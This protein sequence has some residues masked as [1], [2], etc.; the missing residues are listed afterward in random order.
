MS[1]LR[2]LSLG[3]GVQSTVLALMCSEQHQE[4][5]KV[6]CGIFSDT[7]SEPDEV[8][9]HLDWLEKQLSYPIYRVKKG[10]LKEDMYNKKPGSSIP[11]YTK[12]RE[13]GSKGL[14]RRHCTQEYKINPLHKKI[15][16]L[17]GVGYKKR[18]PKGT[19]VTQIFGISY[20]EIIRMRVS[21]KHYI[22]YE[23]PLID[24]RM[25]RHNCLEWMEKN[26]YPRPPRSACTFC[27]YHN[28]QEW[29]RIKEDPKAWAEA[30]EVDKKIREGIAGT[31]DELYLHRSCVPLDQV[32]F[33]PNKN[34][35]NLFD[36]VCDEAM[37]GV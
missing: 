9:T 16:E 11:A 12:N 32:D 25:R 7:M 30:V 1:D 6:N 17:L 24:K 20:D 14:L 33:D 10:N 15:R 34:Q 8:Y 3:A 21:N 36:D 18:V 22:K 5:P 31:K 4:L 35:Q 29:M 37:C 27:P 13:T 23:Y 2:I 26:N 28:N 19:M